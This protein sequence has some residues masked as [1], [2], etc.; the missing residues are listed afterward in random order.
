VDGLV[1]SK[2]VPDRHVLA[3]Y[4]WLCEEQ[5]LELEYSETFGPLWARWAK[6]NPK[7]NEVWDCLEKCIS[8][9]DLA[10]AQQV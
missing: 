10:S 2:A 7:R 8:K 6:T 3:L 5:G 1:K 9:W 4:E